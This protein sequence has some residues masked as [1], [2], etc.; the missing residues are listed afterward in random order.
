MMDNDRIVDFLRRA[1]TEVF[2][3][4]VGIEME[5]G[6]WRTETEAPTV[7]DGVLAV[8]GLGGA[9]TGAGWFICSAAFARQI[10]SRMLM[11]ESTSVDEEVL[12]AVGEFTNMVIGNFKT[13]VEERVGAL[14]LSIPT[15]V[16]GRNFTPRSVGRSDW[17]V[18]PFRFEGESV[19]IRVCLAPSRDPSPARPGFAH[20]AAVIA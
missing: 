19:Q 7:G 4:M 5:V 8:V 9:Y 11:T 2:S 12:D 16:Y 10:C 3:T 13:M 18:Q 17:I 20:P 15:V 14:G 1:A 6:P